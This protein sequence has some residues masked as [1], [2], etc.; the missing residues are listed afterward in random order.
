MVL[1]MLVCTGCSYTH[2]TRT[3]PDG[4]RLEIRNRRFIWASEGVSLSVVD[5]NGI[6]VQLRLQRSSPD[7]AAMA[8]I[9]EG[10]AR[11]AV[12]AVKQ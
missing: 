6:T 4:S 12:K 9:A 2:G 5:T 10:A 11:G 1:A 3:A 8:A 7:A